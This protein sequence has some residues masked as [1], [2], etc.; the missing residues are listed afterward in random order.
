MPF[1]FFN[2]STIIR[3]LQLLHHHSSS[4]I[5]PTSDTTTSGLINTP[6]LLRRSAPTSNPNHL[7]PL[8]H[9]PPLCHHHHQFLHQLPPTLP[10]PPNSTPASTGIFP[11]IICRQ[12]LPHHRG[13]PVG[14][15]CD[16]TDYMVFA[17]HSFTS[18]ICLADFVHNFV[19]KEIVSAIEKAKKDEESGAFL[20]KGREDILARAIGKPEH[21][22]R[23]RGVPQSITITKYFGKGPKNPPRRELIDKIKN[24]ELQMD[25]MNQ[26]KAM[27]MHFWQ[28]GKKPGPE[29]LLSF[30]KASESKCVQESVR[31]SE[32]PSGEVRPPVRE[33]PVPEPPIQEPSVP[34]S[35]VQE[36]RVPEPPVQKPLVQEPPR[37]ELR[38]DQ[39]HLEKVDRTRKSSITPRVHISPAFQ[40]MKWKDC[41]LSLPENQTKMVAYGKVYISNLEEFVSVHGASLRDG[42]KKVSVTEVYSGSKNA[43]LP[44]PSDDLSV[45][46]QAKGSFVQWPQSHI[47]D[48]PIQ[49][50]IHQHNYV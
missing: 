17:K 19:H 44:V 4:S 7:L 27:M 15:L 29:E 28:T 26:M 37:D 14:H 24:L 21:P 13:L 48:P 32:E 33:T 40:D 23:V 10:R 47:H 34:E 36:P 45:L 2:F 50:I 42:F 5:A 25:G 18:Y 46:I 41:V 1:V 49:I 31:V 3:L 35:P 20:P 8:H 11:T 30:V 16:W 12:Q 39:I 38:A 9:L 22:S 43:K 6:A